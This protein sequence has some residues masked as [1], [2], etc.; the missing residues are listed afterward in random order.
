MLDAILAARGG[1]ASFGT[2]LDLGCGTGLMGE[3]LRARSR[4]IEGVDLSAAMVARADAKGVY[5]VL[6]VGE[7]T[8]HLAAEARCFDL[9]AAVDVLIYLGD[10]APLFAAVA[11]RLAESGLFA[12]TA[13]AAAADGPGIDRRLRPSRRFAHAADY[14]LRTGRAHGLVLRTHQRTIL[15]RDGAEA[16]EAHVMVFERPAASAAERP[17]LVQQEMPDDQTAGHQHLGSQVE[18]AEPV[19]Q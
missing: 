13:E 2:A 11:E 15:R 1:G 4:W 14:L 5:D 8:S 19:D 18:H 7:L 6:H 16:I 10:L 3:R 17:V 9:I 12:L